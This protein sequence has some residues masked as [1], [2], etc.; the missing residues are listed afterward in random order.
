[1]TS[2]AMP[3][4]GPPGMA[5]RACVDPPAPTGLPK[6]AWWQPIAIGG[7]VLVS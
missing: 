7:V 5:L 2:P 1:M 6:P 3:L 4:G